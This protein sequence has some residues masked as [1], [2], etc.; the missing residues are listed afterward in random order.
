MAHE[1]PDSLRCET[2]RRRGTH[3]LYAAVAP[4]LGAT[5][6]SLQVD[7][8]EFIWWDEDTF[9]SSARFTG[10]FHMFPA[11]CRLRNAS[12]EFEGRAVRQ[13]KGGKPI[14]IHGLIRD[15]AFQCENHG[16]CLKARIS[17]RPGHQVYEGFPFC[18]DLEL[19]HK[20]IENG[21]EI[22]F[23]IQNTDCRNI[24]FGY[25]LHPFWRIHGRRDEV[26]LRVP[27]PM[28]M[29]ANELIPTGPVRPV[30][31]TPYDLRDFRCLA[32]LNLDT[33]YCRP[34]PGDPVEI[35]YPPIGRRLILTA[36]EAFTHLVV[37]TPRQQPFFCVEHLTSAPNAQNLAAE[38]FAE[39][40]HLLLVPPG[41]CL[42]SWIRYQIVDL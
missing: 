23:V 30:A 33:V 37:Y 22:R 15:E 9:R 31:G 5:I 12:Y 29:D 7:G 27:H 13:T 2:I 35:R 19:T 28:M 20:L 25:G 4:R 1:L 42:E 24:P 14:V 36:G 41:G 21:I 18:C 40:A 39:N 3:D 16:D 26:F 17:I 34:D 8:L 38:G 11:P 10:A 32:D 6:I